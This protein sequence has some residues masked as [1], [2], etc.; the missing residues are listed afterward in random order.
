MVF[1]IVGGTQSTGYEVSN[2][3]RFNDGDSPEL[4]FTPSSAGTQTK[5]T[6]SLWFKLGNITSTRRVLFGAGDD[7]LRIADD[8]N[9]QWHVTDNGGTGRSFYTSAK[10]RD[11]SAWYHVVAQWDT[12]QGT[13]TN[14][15]RLWTNGVEQTA[16]SFTRPSQ[17]AT[18]ETLNSAAEHKLGG[19]LS[20]ANDY[21]FDGYISEFYFIDGYAYDYQDF[22]EFDDNNVWIPKNFT[23][24]YGSNGIRLQFKQTGTSQNSSGIGADTS[25]NDNHFA[26][27]NL[28]ALEVTE[29]TP[30]NNFATLNPLFRSNFD[31]DGSYSEGN[32]QISFTA[33]N[34][35]RGYGFSTFGVT[36]GKWYWEVLVSTVARANTGIGD[37]NAIA[38]FSG[39]I[40]DQNPSK[41]FIVNYNG[42]IEENATATSYANSL[43]N[44]DTVMWALDMDNHRAYY[45]I[46]GTWQ[47]SGDPTSGSTGTGDVTTQISDQSHL[48]TGEPMFPFCLDASTSG[49]SNFKWNFGNPFHTINSGNN[50]GKYGNFEY[51]PPSGY[52]ALCTKR[53]A[54][55]G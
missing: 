4:T 45:G 32:V 22:G 46:N 54:E 39:V 40:Y 31:N 14:R 37:V 10:I 20:P 3:L 51:A 6:I 34:A 53:L 11:P 35:K 12:T 52:Y 18:S 47:D 48:N 44:G 19:E 5:F 41:G 1:P 24:S 36:S 7:Y 17:N 15:M 9:I 13:D 43:S 2:S 16:N 29:D 26:V 8:D 23:G 21:H 50:D 38:G 49:E 42:Q 55:F 33:D 27:S 30:T 28:T 25:G